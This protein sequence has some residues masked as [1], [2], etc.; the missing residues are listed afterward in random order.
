MSTDS[1]IRSMPA[2]SPPPLRR[3]ATPRQAPASPTP[4]SAAAVPATAPLGRPAAP[5]AASRAPA[6]RAD[7]YEDVVEEVLDDVAVVDDDVAGSDEDVAAEEATSAEEP[8]QSWL[9]RTREMWRGLGACSFS[10]IVHG[11]VLIVLAT[12]AVEEPVTNYLQELIASLPEERPPDDLLKTELDQQ[13]E[14]ATQPNLTSSF[15]AADVGVAG[16]GP[17]GASGATGGLV[18]APEL[19]SKVTEAAAG[20]G[21][22]IDGP[23]DFAPPGKELIRETPDGALGDPRAIVDNYEQAMDRITQ[24]VLWM[25][26]K[27][28]VLLVWCFDQSES[29][30]DD[31]KEIRDRIDRVYVELGLANGKE[32]DALLTAVT[33]Y[34][35][36]F[37]IHTK[38]PTSD[39]TLIRSAIDEVPVDP[40]GHEMMCMAVGRSIAA[41]RDVVQRQRRQMALVLVTDES[42]DRP[43]NDRLLEQA[44]AE[45]KAANCKLYI[46]GREAVFG[47][48]YA[49]MRWV[50]PQTGRV[51]WLPIDRGPETGFVEQL[52]IDGFRRRHDAHP[53]GFGSYEQTRMAR[54]T[55]GVFFLLPSLETDLVAGERLR[56]ELEAMRA[57]LP[58]LRSR[59]EVLRDRDGSELRM[60]LWSV[61][62][63]LNPYDPQISKI[64]E[65]RVHFSPQP[66]EFVRQ[67]QTE[68]TKALIYLPHLERAQKELER[69]K[70]LRQQEVS[71]RWQANYDLMYAQLVA[72]QARIFEYGAYLEYFMKNPKRVPLTKP[73][74]LTMTHWDITTRKELLHAKVSQPYVDKATELLQAV[75]RDHAGTPWAAR[76]RY[77]L[78]RGYGVELIPDYEPPYKQP[79]GPVIPVP[80][81]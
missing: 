15:V 32:N 11:I 45:A 80:K 58:D 7:D 78:R 53:S 49:H 34:G 19:D 64:I 30:K 2:A 79:T 59:I 5:P 46:L 47:Y 17:S 71:P 38:K 18:A 41:H 75:I 61:I 26:S 1:T 62:M 42:G 54:E 57:Y 66:E 14:A 40:S 48:P 10:A 50:H 56:Y 39:F 16:D 70:H 69:I 31:Q 37:L 3:P 77:E 27:G 4:R 72:Y 6:P 43:T 60:T 20:S 44:I 28:D 33:S 63:S 21:I 12:M 52:Q 8:R 9:E 35:E 81:Y 23:L 73:P 36:G 68:M 67:A 25:L 51:H 24:E 13:I 76:A 22:S 55:N 65:M 74:N 29:M